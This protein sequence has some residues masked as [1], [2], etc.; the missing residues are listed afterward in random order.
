MQNVRKDKGEMSGAGNNMKTLSI[1]QPW[2]WLIISGHK[3]IE[4]RDWYTGVR[5]RILIHCGKKYDHDG[6]GWIRDE[7]DIEIPGVLPVGGIIGS[8]EI[9]DCVT[10]SDSKWFF[11]KYGFVM[12]N[13]IEL[14]FYQ[15]R[16]QLG[17]FEIPDE[18]VAG[19]Q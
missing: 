2:A 15:Y 18:I 11:G 6:H 5:S 14:P 16:G 1:Q 7:F 13:P 4:N 9:I 3:D 12:R 17:F 8:V 10:K 19:K